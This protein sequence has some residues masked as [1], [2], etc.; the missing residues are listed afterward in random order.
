[1][2]FRPPRGQQLTIEGPAGAL[3]VL[4]EDPHSQAMA[5]EPRSGFGVVCH[6]HPLYGGS[7]LNKVV[8]ML[9][10]GLQEQGLATLRF[11]YRG[12]G[13][14]EGQYDQGRGETADALAVIAWGRARW[15][16][17]PLTLA[18]FSFGS[19]V[20]LMAAPTARPVRMITVAPAVSNASYAAIEQP[21]CPWLIVQGEADEV[22]DYHAVVEFAARFSPPPVLRLLP[23]VDHFFNGHLPQLLEAV[24]QS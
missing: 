5:D 23:G 19:M 12:V 15:P 8:H 22:V 6:P 2:S 13:L 21:R 17:V 9:A 7:M 18:G 4:L 16:Q 24:L 1:L 14:S 20:A 11:N 3:E 10:R